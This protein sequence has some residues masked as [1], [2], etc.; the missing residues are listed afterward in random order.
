M[1]SQNSVC[2]TNPKASHVQ[3]RRTISED[4]AKS[5]LTILEQEC[6]YRHGDADYFV[7]YITDSKHPCLE[8]RFCGALG[9]G[10]KFRNNGN[11]NDTPY[12]DCY[13]EHETPER[14][15]MIKRANARLAQLFDQL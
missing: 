7:R 5:V 14:T 3:H 4:Q 6:G 15:A 8:F 1:R 9:F 12:V 2:A 13:K 11:R 10:G